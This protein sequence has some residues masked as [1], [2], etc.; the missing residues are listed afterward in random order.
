LWTEWEQPSPSAQKGIYVID[1]QDPLAANILTEIDLL[2]QELA[3]NDRDG[4]TAHL[5]AMFPSF[6]AKRGKSSDVIEL[7]TT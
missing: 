2:E 6:A 3:A 4:I 5:H 1:R 7:Q